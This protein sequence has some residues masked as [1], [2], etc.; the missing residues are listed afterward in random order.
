MYDHTG[1]GNQLY[2]HASIGKPQERYPK[3]KTL[4]NS[5]LLDI[6]LTY[7]ML[8]TSA[9]VANI[10]YGMPYHIVDIDKRIS[11]RSGRNIIHKILSI[12]K[13]RAFN[14]KQNIIMCVHLLSTKITF[15]LMVELCVNK[16]V[17]LDCH[18]KTD[19]RLRKFANGQTT[20]ES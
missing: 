8:Y 18:V 11:S 5:S 6:I 16:T 3:H 1:I 14:N 17:P 9:P 20:S 13:T 15:C 2:V 7:S 4:V 12:H 10:F 19:E